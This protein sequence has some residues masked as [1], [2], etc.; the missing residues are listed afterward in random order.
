MKKEINRYFRLLRKHLTCSKASRNR[1][2]SQ[3]QRTAEEFLNDKPNVSITDIED[4]LGSPKAL[5]ETFMETLDPT[6]IRRSKR[7]K[8]IARIALIILPVVIITLLCVLI[9]YITQTQADIEITQE[10]TTTIYE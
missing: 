5:A 2:I 1:F 4:F 7:N 3:T 9:Y 8:R 6:E 10:I